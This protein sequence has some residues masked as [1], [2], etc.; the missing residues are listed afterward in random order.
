MTQLST[1]A[2]FENLNENQRIVVS[3]GQPEP[4]KHHTKK[5]RLWTLN[6]YTGY[7]YGFEYSC[8]RYEIKISSK[9]GS[10]LVNVYPANGTKTFCLLN[11]EIA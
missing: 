4:P 1:L 8:G 5:H 10:M 7:F 9:P 3:D 2:E 6:N 11:S